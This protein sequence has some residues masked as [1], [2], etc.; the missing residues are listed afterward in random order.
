ML[1]MGSCGK[2][3]TPT[4]L[5]QEVCDALARWKR[6]SHGVEEWHHALP[7]PKVHNVPCSP[8][9]SFK[10]LRLLGIFWI[11]GYDPFQAKGCAA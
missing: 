9:F 6:E 11:S 8:T 7:R 10:M 2:E 4:N 5:L 1:N 3:V